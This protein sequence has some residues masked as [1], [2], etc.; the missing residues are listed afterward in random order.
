LSL[1]SALRFIRQKWICSGFF[2]PLIWTSRSVLAFTAIRPR[3]I[4]VGLQSDRDFIIAASG[5]RRVTPVE[6][7]LCLSHLDEGQKWL[8]AG[9]DGSLP[10]KSFK[11][12]FPC[13]I[14]LLFIIIQQSADMTC[15]TWNCEMLWL[16]SLLTQTFWIII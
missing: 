10:L 14:S 6:V 7:H 9:I 15:P 8:L 4:I 12:Q 2:P 3:P 13:R 1:I 16:N 11:L 5:Y